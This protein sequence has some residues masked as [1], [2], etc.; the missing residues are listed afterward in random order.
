MRA[1]TGVGRGLRH[2]HPHRAPRVPVTAP[3]VLL[4]TH[5]ADHFTIDRV[6]AAVARRGGRP[7]R[8]DSDQFPA[9]VRLSAHSGVDGERRVIDVDGSVLDI[10]QV[11]AVWAR[12]MWPAALDPALDER[13]RGACE[14]E[15]RA[16]LEAF[17]GGLSDAHWINAPAADRRAGDKLLQL[18]LARTHGLAVPETLLTND[19]G[20]ARTFFDRAGGDVVAKMLTPF[21]TSMEGDG[22]F[23]YTSPVTEQDLRDAGALRHSP[24]L[25]QRRVPKA[26]ELRVA[27]VRGRHFVG[28][29]DATATVEGREDWRRSEAGATAWVRGTLPEP[30]GSALRALLSALGLEYAATDLIVTPEGE[31]VFLE[32]NPGGEWGML[33]RDLD[34]GIS[35]ALADAL[36]AE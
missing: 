3:T 2:S 22:A 5:R 31:H 21:S 18:R 13:F 10:A 11:R 28:A 25:F 27:T 24:M 30:V 7:F 9:T 12:R 33:E 17:L 19:P 16:A 26:L 4:V 15:S 23:V 6:A 36:C 32:V 34:L 29:V 20:A 8:F 14:R 1:E 35:D